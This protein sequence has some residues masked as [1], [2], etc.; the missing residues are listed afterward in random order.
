MSPKQ[1]SMGLLSYRLTCATGS[2]VVYLRRERQ[3][4]PRALS[5]ASCLPDRRIPKVCLL[6]ASRNWPR[7][8]NM[9]TIAGPMTLLSRPSP[10]CFHLHVA[11]LYTG[12]ACHGARR[13]Q[14]LDSSLP[15]RWHSTGLSAR[16]PRPSGHDRRQRRAASLHSQ[17]S[18]QHRH[19][20]R[21]VG[22]RHVQSWR[23][24]WRARGRAGNWGYAG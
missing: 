6:A 17:G 18:R 7:F 10:P 12:R 24:D 3:R 4:P 23:V 5:G 19:R 16:I 13:L 2:H 1:R 15:C 20:S 22:Y 21:Q 14:A 9:L 8:L 11:K